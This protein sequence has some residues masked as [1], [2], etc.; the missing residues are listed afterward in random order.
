MAERYRTVAFLVYPETMPLEDLLHNI[1]LLHIEAFVSPLHDPDVDHT[2]PHYHV[3]FMYESQ[4]SVK[5]IREDIHKCGAVNDFFIHPPRRSYARYLLHLDNLD[6]QQFGSEDS[7]YCLNGA[8]FAPYLCSD[9][10]GEES[11]LVAFILQTIND[12]Q[13]TNFRMLVDAFSDNLDCLLILRKFTFFFN[14][15][16]KS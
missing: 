1:E 9:S 16:L 10:N 12:R 13:I 2:K 8:N 11:G 14:T 15:Y 7:V 3:L 5:S 6:K 4:Q